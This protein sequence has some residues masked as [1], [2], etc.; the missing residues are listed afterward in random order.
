MPR[1]SRGTACLGGARRCTHV[2]GI[3]ARGQIQL[4]GVF[5]AFDLVSGTLLGILFLG[6][7]FTPIAFIGVVLVVLAGAGVVWIASTSPLS[8]T[9]PDRFALHLCGDL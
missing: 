8:K 3:H 4:L 5:F 7:F 1:A 2:Y 9:D 6:Q